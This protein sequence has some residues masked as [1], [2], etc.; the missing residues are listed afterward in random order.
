MHKIGVDIGARNAEGP[1]PARTSENALPAA[2]GKEKDPDSR[3]DTDLC[4][5]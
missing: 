2:V 3:G 5:H 4:T 1:I